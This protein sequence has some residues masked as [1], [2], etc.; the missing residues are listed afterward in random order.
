MKSARLAALVLLPFLAGCDGDVFGIGR[1]FEGVYAYAGTVDQEL[2]DAVIGEFV[3]TR[4]RHDR[5]LVSLDWSYLDQG[6]EIVRITTQ[7]PADAELWSDGRIRFDFEGELITN[8]EVVNF[9]LEHD[10][11]LHRGTMTGFWRLTTGLP[12]NDTGTFTASR[13]N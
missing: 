2:G 12:T 8:G 1:D 6:V 3:I 5:A 9:R 13:N 10:G 7:N 11:Q 4:Q